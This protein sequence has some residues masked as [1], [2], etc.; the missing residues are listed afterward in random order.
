MGFGRLAMF[1]LGRL[2]LVF[3]RLILRARVRRFSAASAVRPDDPLAAPLLSAFRADDLKTRAAACLRVSEF[4]WA[5][6]YGG[7]SFCL[8]D[9][10]KAYRPDMVCDAGLYGF[11]GH[12]PER[13]DRGPPWLI[14]CDYD[15][16]VAD[17]LCVRA[18]PRLPAHRARV[19]CQTSRD[20]GPPENR[21]E[22]SSNVVC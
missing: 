13:Y 16:G 8:R 14:G 20:C 15:T 6:R 18:S 9:A 22:Q 7:T 2:I 19:T 5:A 10:Y 11:P 17:D 3:G 1:L 12:E 21:S 4:V